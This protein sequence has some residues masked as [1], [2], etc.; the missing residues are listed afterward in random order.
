MLLDSILRLARD[1]SQRRIAFGLE[2][3]KF[4]LHM[5]T[6][7]RMEVEVRGSMLLVLKIAIWLGKIECGVATDKESLL[8]RLMSPIA[9]LYTAKQAVSV[10]SEGLE[11]FGG[12]GY[13]ED[14]GLPSALRDAQVLPIWEGTTNILSLDVLRCFAK[15]NGEVLKAFVSSSKAC[16]AAG[17]SV[18]S[19]HRACSKVENALEDIGN[20]V[21]NHPHLLVVAARDISYSIARTYIGALLLENASWEGSTR[22]DVSAARRWCELQDLC[23]FLSQQQL[24]NYEPEGTKQDSSLVMEGYRKM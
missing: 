11:A 12:Q 8:L 14:T 10:I 22:E 1:Y 15:T 9:K 19:L 24:L 16:I 18:P 21:Q 13:I 2:I 3:G 6:L 17:K 7:S 5:Q 4:P 20:F 23:P